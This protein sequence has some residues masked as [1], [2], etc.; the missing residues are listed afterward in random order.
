MW[1][2]KGT[3]NADLYLI[4]GRFRVAC[5]METLMRCKPDAVLLMHDYAPRP[6]YHVVEQFARP[7][8]VCSTLYAF[9]RRGNFNRTKAGETLARFS[10]VPS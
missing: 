7:F 1:D 2:L 6:E 5:F 4:D 10:Q 9:I 8:M 3:D